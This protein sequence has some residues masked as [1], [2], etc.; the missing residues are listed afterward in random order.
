MF[1]QVIDFIGAKFIANMLEQ[2]IK[3]PLASA[4]I[5]AASSLPNGNR[6]LKFR[7]GSMRVCG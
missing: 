5:G 1:T 2:R 7:H 3:S 6:C 4:S